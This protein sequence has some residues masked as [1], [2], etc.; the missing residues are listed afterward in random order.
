M[1]LMLI[2]LLLL[3]Y[4]FLAE[5]ERQ[6]RKR[7]KLEDKL[8]N[9][10][11]KTKKVDVVAGGEDNNSSSDEEIEKITSDTSQKLNNALRTPFER[12]EKSL[13]AC[14]S[15]SQVRRIFFSFCCHAKLKLSVILR[16]NI[17]CY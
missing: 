11:K 7:R 12:W 6:N 10:Y 17:Q 9:K 2:V 8:R 4:F 14:S 13:M 5:T 1:R 3:F 16:S 15:L